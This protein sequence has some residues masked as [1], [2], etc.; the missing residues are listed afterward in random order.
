MRAQKPRNSSE[1]T[2]TKV[3]VA[4]GNESRENALRT[5][6][7]NQRT[8]RSLPQKRD[9]TADCQKQ[10]NIN[11]RPLLRGQ[12]DGDKRPESGLHIGDEEGEPVESLKT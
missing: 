9:K 10:P 7:I 2:M 6:C 12:I 5:D 8:A 4:S 3:I 11:L 1:A